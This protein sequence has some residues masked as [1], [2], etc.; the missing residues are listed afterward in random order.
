MN[1]S[2]LCFLLS[3]HQVMPVFLDFI[4]PFGEQSE[5]NDSY[6]GGLRDEICLGTKQRGIEISRFKRSGSELRLCYN[7]R[8]VE[9]AFQPPELPWSIHHSAV[10]HSFDVENGQSLWINIKDN[11]LLED[12]ITDAT[13]TSSF[14]SDPRTLDAA[15]SA[16]LTIHL[17]LCDWSCENWRGYLNDLE[18][19]FHRLAK[20]APHIPRD[21]DTNSTARST[22][23]D[24]G[25]IS[26]RGTSR[27]IATTDSLATMTAAKSWQDRRYDHSKTNRARLTVVGRL[28][29]GLHLSFA[30]LKN[31]LSRHSSQKDNANQPSTPSHILNAKKMPEGML[32]DSSQ[33]RDERL[34]EVYTSTA[35]QAI[36]ELE[37]KAQE[38]LLVLRLNAEV[39]K[40]LRRHYHSATSH[41]AFPATLKSQCEVEFAKFNKKV[42][43]FENELHMLQLRTET[44]LQIIASNKGLVIV[45]PR[46]SHKGKIQ[47]IGF[48][49]EQGP[50]IS[51]RKS[52][53]I[54]C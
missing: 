54:V 33:D 23:V 34:Q 32:P 47:L 10:Y 18:S 26:P 53:R 6:F 50:S 52:K 16:S 36:Q 27:A 30:Y 46:G 29:K 1:R 17:C 28:K 37:D 2:M 48:Q 11:G 45:K 49:V 5:T 38:A 20:E 14:V 22:R 44:L 8:S 43:D 7:L 40:E 24:T 42:L 31:S 19:E 39:L 35:L 12:R 21:G 25:S 9:P 13:R 15:F 41:S 4:F 3:Y 51:R